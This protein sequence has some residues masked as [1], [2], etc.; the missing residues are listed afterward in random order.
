M[1]SARPMVQLKLPKNSKVNKNGKTFAAPA[2]AKKI[3]RFNVYRYD[4]DTG[5]N[6]RVDSYDVDMSGV[7]MAL[8]GLIKIKNE[9]DP[10]LAFRR[11]CREGVCGSCAFNINGA[12]TLAC[13]KSM[14][15]LGGGPVTVYPLPHQ[16]V[17]KDL[18]TDL[19]TFYEQH[20]YIEPFLQAKDAEPED[21]WRQSQT[22]RA[23]LD[24]LYECILCACCSTGC[25]SYWWNGDKGGQD[26]Y[27]GPAALLQAYRWLADSRDQHANERLDRLEDEFKLYRCH[28]IFN[29]TQVCPKHLNPAKAITEIKKLMM[30]RPPRPKDAPLAGGT[31][32]TARRKRAKRAAAD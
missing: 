18:V 28:T 22:D 31:L 30:N 12:N 1:E 3:R 26:E 15:D 16:A 13:T 20:A 32:K 2:G 23:K 29:C 27:L 10:S 7:S 17:V 25:P 19:T 11:S 14:A 9:M 8:D 5:E 24:G 6:P 4:P 21:E